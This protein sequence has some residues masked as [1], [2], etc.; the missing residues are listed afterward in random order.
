MTGSLQIKGNKYYV[1]LNVKNEFGKPK[2][3]WV[4]TGIST[5]GNNKRAAKEKLNQI[6]SDYS[7]LDYSFDSDILF[8]DFINQWYNYCKDNKI[9]AQN[10]LE[11]YLEIIET[12]IIP[13]WKP[14]RIKLKN[15]NS[16]MLERFYR[17]QYSNGRLDGKGGLAIGTIKSYHIIINNVF[18]KAIRD[19]LIIT[20]PAKTA[21]LPKANSSKATGKAYTPNQIKELFN[22][23]QNEYLYPLIY[24]TLMYGLRISEV[25]GLKWKAID[26]EN[27]TIEVNH[28]VVQAVTLIQKDSTKTQKSH[29]TYPLLPSVEK[30]LL[31]VKHRQECYKFL[32]GNT[33]IENDYVFTNQNGSISN[34]KSVSAVFGQLLK[35]HNL[36]HMRFH[37]LRHSCASMLINEGVELKMVSEWLGHSNIYTTAN[38]Y[39]HLYDDSKQEIANTIQKILID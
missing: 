22:S 9:V 27:K 15:V 33:Y 26:F 10:T 38:I 11:N 25:C 30:I 31:D 18:N 6:I 13:Y 8:V 4:S 16:E 34:P 28:V 1:V 24:T 35:K 37:D 14:M 29:R 5:K 17:D 3:K 12:H 7:Y 36:P 20:N 32:L 39:G 2:K 23:I 19:K 21:K